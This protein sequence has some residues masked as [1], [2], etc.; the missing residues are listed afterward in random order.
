MAPRHCI[1]TSAR[2]PSPL[3]KG[4]PFHG[5][6]PVLTT[7]VGSSRCRSSGVC[8]L[9]SPS[10]LCSPVPFGMTEFREVVASHLLLYCIA[11][12]GDLPGTNTASN[13]LQQL[14]SCTMSKKS[15]TICTRKRYLILAMRLAWIRQHGRS[16]AV[17]TLSCPRLHTR[18]TLHYESDEHI[19]H[20]C[21]PAASAQLNN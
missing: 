17:S 5:R 3:F 12:T 9:L 8:T 15:L 21:I 20:C 7:H 18:Q 14:P 6:E 11:S 4:A 19:Y 16:I 1:L 10:S 13:L 2:S